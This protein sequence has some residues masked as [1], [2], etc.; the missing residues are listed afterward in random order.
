[1]S[2]WWT[3]RLRVALQAARL[4]LTWREWLCGDPSPRSGWRVSLVNRFLLK[5]IRTAL[6]MRVLGNGFPRSPP[7]TREILAGEMCGRE[8]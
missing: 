4:N 3:P 5:A 1:M 2:R 7:V 8:T 6:R